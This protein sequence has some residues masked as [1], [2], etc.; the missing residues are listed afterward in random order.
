M[1][2]GSWQN[3]LIAFVSQQVAS[4]QVGIFSWK[5]I[6]IFSIFLFLPSFVFATPAAI[7]PERDIIISDTS[8]EPEW[9][10][11]WDEARELT[12]QEQYV[13]AARA[14][15]HLLSLKKNIEEASWEYCLVL[16]ALSDWDHASVVV[17]DLL[18]GDPQRTEY[19]LSA[20]LVA[21]KKKEYAR[22]STY[23]GLVYKKKA[24]LEESQVIE[25]LTGLVSA[26]H[27][28]GKNEAAYPYMEQLLQYRPE[29]SLLL[30]QL[31]IQAVKSGRREKALVYYTN[32]VSQANVEDQV[33]LEAAKV[34]EEFGEKTRAVSCWEKYLQR[35]PNYRPFQEKIANYFIA[36]GEKE[37]ALPHLLMLLDQ[38]NQRDDRL[39]E[40]GAIYLSDLGKPDKALS[41]YEEYFQR[42]PG[43]QTI[44][45]EIVKIQA[46]LAH[47]LLSRIEH[48]GALPLWKE[49]VQITSN[50]L[51]IY[52]SLAKLLE[53]HGN[54]K[55]L[56]E[57]LAIIHQHAPGNKEVIL[58]LA[59]LFLEQKDM[60]QVDHF[61][62]L[63]PQEVM[64]SD[65][66][67]MPV[68]RGIEGAVPVEPRFL[69]TSGRLADLRG[70]SGQALGWYKRYLQTRPGDEDIRLRCMD[71]AAQL[72]LIS[73]YQDF[74]HVLRREAKSDL[75]RLNIDMRYAGVLLENGLAT[76]AKKVYQKL[77]EAGQGEPGRIAEIRLALADAFYREGNIFEAEQ[78]LRQ[79]LVDGVAMRSV[80]RKLVEFSIES[81][82]PD[83][84]KTW[85]TLLSEQP[86]YP[87]IP[88]NCRGNEDDFD[89]LRARV[90]AASGKF[91]KAVTS[92][93]EYKELL[94][95]HCPQSD[96]MRYQADLFLSYLYLQDKQYDKGQELITRLLKEHPLDLEPL[97]I[98][99]QLAAGL[100]GKAQ[101]DRVDDVLSKDYS[102]RFQSLMQA[103]QL[104]RTYGDLEAANKHV[105]MALKEVPDSIAAR[106]L[107]ADICEKEGR[108]ETS[109]S[110]LQSLIVD[111]PSE[112][113]FTRKLLELEFKQASFQKIIKD[114]A[115]A[116]QL[117]LAK[118][119]MTFPDSSHLLVWQKLI[120]AR[121]LWADRQWVAAVAVY[122]AVLQPSVERLFTERIEKQHIQLDL[123]P[124]K[125]SFL[126]VITFTHPA[127][128]DRLTVVMDPTFVMTQRGMPVG[129][130]GADLYADYRWQQLVAR[131]L[132]ARR[133]LA[134]G[135][136][137]QAM[138]EYQEVVEKN[139]S[140]ES[141]FDLAGIYSRLGF[142]GKE[143]LLYEEIERENPGY[144][145]L[146]ESVQRNS[147]KR[148]PRGM[149]DSGYSSLS[150]RDGYFDR[151]Q[152]R[153]GASV[154]MLPTLR[155]E[156][157]VSWSTIHA[158]SADTDQALWR[159]RLLAAYSFY[160]HYNVDFITR[161]GMD[162]P[163]NEYNQPHYDIIPLI[164][165]EM[166]GRIGDDLHAFV[167]LDQ[168]V[169]DDTVQ[170]LEQG[171]SRRD[172]EGGV[173]M[174]ILPRLFCGG[175][176]LFR[177][178]SDANHQN[179][180]HVWATYIIHSEPTLLQ[181]TYGQE[182]Q[183]NAEVNM[184]RDFSYEN[185]FMPGDHPYWSPKEYWQNL[186]SVHFEHQLAADVLGRS[187][188][189][190]YNLD[191]S[192][193]YDNGG[194][195]SHTFGGD[196]F[197]EMSRH[198]LLSSSFEIIQ[199]GPVIRKD[200]ALSLVYRW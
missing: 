53:K 76:E 142:L 191:Y 156:M 54:S 192:F 128:P 70:L 197:L 157:D 145:E 13:E 182:F 24:T 21:L 154:W 19:L 75:E 56:R 134:Q 58:R 27:G 52:S 45:Q 57:V 110:I 37:A 47:N 189:S 144:P 89:L 126:N 122:D 152:T 30:H 9:K 4:Q 94:A 10:L 77:I 195:D 81:N 66:G 118:G 17:A 28:Q 79:M 105:L 65:E 40:I 151:Q 101:K 71:L 95:Q 136:Y 177:E 160:P 87:V 23:Y 93:L 97:I 41:F 67:S 185:G 137:Y 51:A 100:S 8:K 162:K 168:D 55:E 39:L 103:A 63:L 62:S 120:L 73:Q 174:D 61:L 92:V 88:A 161:V 114:L 183:H 164:H 194:Y 170:A 96:G 166:R 80:L 60:G 46:L 85:L 135:E 172:V 188:P 18:E 130:I 102:N 50:P 11:L 68:E 86:G 108:L 32:L 138:K 116:Q 38:D 2:K 132:S 59:E 190:Y 33:L 158:I 148:K 5:I 140:P 117:G 12:R 112:L 49:L 1:V 147:L 31:A 72:G 82:E 131:E 139:S 198:F 146:A 123:P 121:S 15:S 167:R 196:I 186:V 26:L 99:Q 83:L 3:R 184:G 113:S 125:Q 64:A 155:Q 171:I 84:A 90:L 6:L 69:L 35:Y 111:Y 199:G 25:A 43:N 159:N 179:R 141:L 180:Y 153:G 16:I 176:Y 7:T 178:Y 175:E 181:V 143:A 127:E 173:R 44:G 193:G 200:V 20:G 106:A 42:H 29:D 98:G 74:Y 104:E 109:F 36:R 133:A 129:R 34:F 150:G 163:V 48:D 107:H 187:A 119:I 169:V 22:A 91:G 165:L 115:P 124:P 14:Y 78:V 149:I